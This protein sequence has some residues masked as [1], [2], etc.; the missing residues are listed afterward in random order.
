MRTDKQKITSQKK[1]GARNQ[2]KDL[3]NRREPK[4]AA[5]QAHP[6]KAVRRHDENT[7]HTLH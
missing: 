6:R 1:E 2:Q 4:S 5:K 3:E 7:G